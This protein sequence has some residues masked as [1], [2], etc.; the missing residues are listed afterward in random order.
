MNK[1]THVV[2][3]ALG[4]VGCA[5]ATDPTTSL[6][7]DAP[8]VTGAITT[9]T[10]SIVAPKSLIGRTDASVSAMVVDDSGRPSDVTHR[11]TWSSSNVLVL[12]VADGKLYTVGA[13]TATV[14]ATLGEVT[15]SVDVSVVPKALVSV[16]ILADAE[17]AAVGQ[18]RSWALLAQYNDGTTNDV[19]EDARWQSS[20]ESIA[21]V[22]VGGAV[23][24]VGN[25]MTTIVASYAGQMAAAPFL[26][27]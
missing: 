3:M 21:T 9:T 1:L 19:S 26:V 13:G 10:L 6:V 7:D 20:D 24:A 16:T 5:G 23:L 4:L 18:S 8:P 12:A 25:G 11:V 2:V 22:G 27:P 14:R 17:S 15:T